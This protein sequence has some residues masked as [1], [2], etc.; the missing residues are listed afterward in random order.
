MIIRITV[1]DNKGCATVT[2]PVTVI[3]YPNY[4]TPNGD[5]HNEFWNIGDLEKDPNAKNYIFDRYGKLLKQIKPSRSSGWDGTM[6]AQQLPSTD[7]WFT[8]TY[9][10]NGEIKE[11]KAHFS[12]KR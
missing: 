12:L 11:F 8:V 4:F 6:N 3:N 9:T 2:I 1:Y 5:D 7:Y 10:E